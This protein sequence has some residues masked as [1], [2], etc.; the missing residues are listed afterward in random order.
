M[1]A[2]DEQSIALRANIR[3]NVI[4]RMYNGF[5]M[6]FQ[7]VNADTEDMIR[8]WMS[9]VPGMEERIN[10]YVARKDA[11]RAK[12]YA[13]K[14]SL[15]GMT[16]EDKN[17][18]V[19]LFEKRESF[20]EGERCEFSGGQIIDMYVVC[21]M[22]LYARTG[23]RF[24]MP[25]NKKSDRFGLWIAFCDM[26]PATA[27]TMVKDQQ[28]DDDDNNQG[29]QPKK[30]SRDVFSEEVLTEMTERIER[31]E[32]RQNDYERRAKVLRRNSFS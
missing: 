5:V 25:K 15:R 24:S 18:I 16:S 8:H 30:R 12:G 1:T 31:L 17:K 9:C 27:A 21:S 3:M 10:S 7:A 19:S 22:Y 13:T 2:L 29:A 20:E 6:A 11:M 32:K 23:K 28:N 4:Q 14:W 26:F